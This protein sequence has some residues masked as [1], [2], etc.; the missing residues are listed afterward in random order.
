MI[1]TNPLDVVKTRLQA[2]MKSANNSFSS[3]VL[4][5]GSTTVSYDRFLSTTRKI[6]VEEGVLRGLVVPGMTAALLRETAYSSIRFGLYSRV[7]VLISGEKK[8]PT[9]LQKMAAG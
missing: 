9:I 7:K 3:S 6:A 4:S 1:V 8:D 2:Q 5:T